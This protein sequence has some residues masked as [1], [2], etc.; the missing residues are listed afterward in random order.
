MELTTYSDLDKKW[1]ALAIDLAWQGCYTTSPN[2]NVGCVIVSS[3]GNLVGQGAHLK[4]GEAHAEVH[5]LRDAGKQA[6]GATAFVTLEPCSHTGRTP[7][8]AN[9]LV[10]AGVKRVVVANVDPNPLVAGRGIKKL[11]E[12]GIETV[13]GVLADKAALLN[14]GFFK[15]M[16]QGKPF[17]SLK[18]AASMDG[19]IAL[20]NGQSKWITGPEARRDVQRFRA[21]SCAILT[22]SGTVRADD[23][24]LLIRPEQAQIDDYPNLPIRQPARY[25]IDS[26]GSL[27]DTF[28]IFNDGHKTIVFTTKEVTTPGSIEYCRVKQVGNHVDLDAMLMELGKREVNQLWVESGATLAGQLLSQQ[29][30]DELIIYLAPK[31]LGD[32]GLPMLK[33]P[34]YSHLAECP[35]L[36]LKDLTLVGQDVRLTY[37]LK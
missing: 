2:P 22:G 32:Q 11:N 4:A 27:P 7:P 9:A 21:K 26:T 19:R 17:V 35:E 34:Q 20:S 25:V 3:D 33:L 29:L 37:H 28:Q 1:M 5:A 36:W 14:R 31:L 24:S 8:C 15:R 10:N 6:K 30:V 18:L 16:K 12:H 23:P 13:T